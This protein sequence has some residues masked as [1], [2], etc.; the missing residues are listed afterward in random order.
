M[1][2]PATSPRTAA[3]PPSAPLPSAA[4]PSPP[5]RPAP[6][7]APSTWWPTPPP[8]PPTPSWPPPSPRPRPVRA[9][10]SPPPSGPRAPRPPRWS[11]GCP[12]D[13]V[14]F[15]LEPDMAKVVKAGLVS[16]SWDK[17]RDQGHGDELHRLVHRAPGQSE[18]HHHLGRP[19]EAGRQVSSRPTSSARA[20]PSG[21]S[22]RPTAPRSRWASRRR[23]RRPTSS[24]LLKNAVAQ[25]S[26]ASAAL[27]TFLS[28]QGDVL[29]DYEDD[30]LYAKSQGEPVTVITRRRRS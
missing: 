21:T 1:G 8:S 24:K 17:R 9:S 11:T 19:G 16:S 14:N 20:A 3:A 2:A 25:P 18:A 10:P 23:R 29:L 27:Q 13:V 5:C 22:W 12:A 7:A 6:R 4:W 28:G 15:S 26:S 30:G